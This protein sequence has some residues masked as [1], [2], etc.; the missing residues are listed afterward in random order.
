MIFGFNTDIKHD[1]V[2][3]HVQSEARTADLL[4]QTQV[5]V[6]GRCIGK[7]ATSYADKALE[8]GFSDDNMHEMLKAQHKNIIEAVKAG[9]VESL[10]TPTLSMKPATDPVKSGIQD[11][12]E[13][14]NGLVLQWLNSD[15]IYKDNSVV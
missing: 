7:H 2:V 3:Y 9:T 10:F 15:A 12:S 11:A 4:L 1:D 6:R 14:G 8:P 5:F 13:H